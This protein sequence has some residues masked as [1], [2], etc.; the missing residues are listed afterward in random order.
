MDNLN[1]QLNGGIPITT[2]KKLILITLLLSF[3]GFVS[4]ETAPVDY[5]INNSNYDT[6]R[7]ISSPGI[8]NLTENITNSDGIEINSDNVTL[9]G[10]GYFLNVT[11]NNGIHASG[12]KNITITDVNLCASGENASAINLTGAEIIILGNTITS[13]SGDG[14]FINRSSENITISANTITAGNKGVYCGGN[15]ATIF[16]NIITSNYSISMAGYNLTVEN[17]A[18]TSGIH[19]YYSLIY[20]NTLSGNTING[21]KLYFYKNIENVGEIPSDAGQVILVNCTNAQISNINFNEK[22]IAISIAD[23]T[24]V[25]VENCTI[26]P[27]VFTTENYV[28]MQNSENCEFRGNT[29]KVSESN[30]NIGFAASYVN[31]ITISKNKFEGIFAPVFGVNFTNS[32]IFKNIF[33]NVPIAPLVF[34]YDC[35]GTYVYLNNFINCSWNVENT[36]NESITFNSP[37][38]VLY[39]YNGTTYST[40][41]GNYWSDYNETNAN[42][43]EGIWSIPYAITELINDSYPLA[44]PFS[45]VDENGIIHITLDDVDSENGYVITKPGTYVLDE[46]ITNGGSILINSSNATFDGNGHCINNSKSYAVYSNAEM[47]ENLTVKNVITSGNISIVASNSNLSSTDALYVS[48]YGDYN[49]ISK[50]RAYNIVLHGNNNTIFNNTAPYIGAAFGNNNK[51][52]ANTAYTIEIYYD[53]RDVISSNTVQDHIWTWGQYT[54]IS[55]NTVINASYY[56]IDP[57]GYYDEGI[58]AYATVFNNTVLAS[59]IGIW[60]DNYC[61]G[62]SNITQNTVYAS[63]YPIFIGDNI[64][65]CNIYLNNFIYTGN[66]TNISEI[67]PNTTVNNSLVSP[68]E[69]EYKY[70]GNTYSNL[71]G[72]Y[73]SDYSGT[74]ADS[75]GIGDIPYLYGCDYER[76][77]GDDYYDIDYLENDTA[78][79]IDM[80]NGNEIGNYVAPVTRSSGSSGRS[81]DSDIS[82]EIDSKVIKNFVSSASVIYGN[83][84][85]QQYA[86]ELRERIQNANGYKISGNAV[87]VGG[88][89]ANGF[90]K[91]YNNQFEM[92]ISNDYPGENKGIIQVLKVQE[93]TG[94]IVQSYTIAY[95]AGS[96]RLGTQAALE[97]FKTL[98]ELPDGPIMVEWTANGPK[99]VE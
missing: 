43:N 46:D 15:N 74:D 40:I 34:R 24:G 72:N 30:A 51:I 50:N 2:L 26:N 92:P 38:N 35:S 7:T 3:I 18:L 47:L 97:Y 90:A 10:Q 28:F 69:I 93:N 23:S 60:L 82:D 45:M 58:D 21:K 31:N 81:Y 53:N 20:S 88:P 57:N 59:N 48:F 33:E 17:N 64:T 42:V 39:T 83:E 4:A 95:I 36:L 61:E 49:T 54:T 27:S 89:N 70:N 22:A 32:R 9:N 67:M 5:N 65:G 14:I 1:I 55:S 66:S 6:A 77:Y 11:S 80:W 25:I 71:L 16:G 79:L 63:E 85:D 99:V 37:L 96:D 73:W 84:I 86:E 68:F 87:I 78:P 29:F 56:A 41:A 75:N 91:E 13:N 8:Y 94:K 98:D 52:L 19:C 44:K 12:Y 62:Y 76:T